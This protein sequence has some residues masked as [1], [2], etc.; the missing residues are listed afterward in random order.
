MLCKKLLWWGWKGKKIGKKMW[1]KKL[2][3]E[4]K[5]ERMVKRLKNAY[6]WVINS[7]YFFYYKMNSIVLPRSDPERVKHQ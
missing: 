3:R 7:K 6:F 1:G 4:K 5:K 2:Q